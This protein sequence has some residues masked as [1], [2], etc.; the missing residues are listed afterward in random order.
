MTITSS[1]VRK[2]RSPQTPRVHIRVEQSA[3]DEAIRGDSGHC[4][5]AES[6]KKSVSTARSVSVDLASIRWTDSEKKLRYVYFTPR[7]AQVSLVDFDHGDPVE[8]FEFDLKLAK[9]F[10]S[11]MGVVK[12]KTRTKREEEIK[13]AKKTKKKAPKAHA[14]APRSLG[15][16]K[17]STSGGT[18]NSNVIVGGNAPPL[19]PLAVADLTTDAKGKRTVNIPIARRRAF[20]LRLLRA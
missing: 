15:S 20:G 7:I 2:T 17:I 18:R 12:K 16:A 13:E 4:M 1:Y 9:V 3:I 14:P 8:P 11:Q 19:G 10:Q 6:I 5:I